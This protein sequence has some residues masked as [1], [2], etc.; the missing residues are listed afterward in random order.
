MFSIAPKMG[1]P[2]LTTPTPPLMRY[3]KNT[4]FSIQDYIKILHDLRDSLLQ[5]LT[6]AAGWYIGILKNVVKTYEYI[7]FFT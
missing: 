6:L 4:D 7:Y 2:G 3:L 1:L 5:T